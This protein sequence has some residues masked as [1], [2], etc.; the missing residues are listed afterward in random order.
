MHLQLLWLPRG[1]LGERHCSQDLSYSG[2]MGHHVENLFSDAL[3]EKN[4]C[5]ILGTSV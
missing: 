4:V 5:A 2:A 1:Y 3:G